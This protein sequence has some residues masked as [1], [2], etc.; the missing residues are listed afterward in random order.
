MVH[1]GR[2]WKPVREPLRLWTGQGQG[3]SPAGAGALAFV[4]RLVVQ[5]ANVDT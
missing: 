5:I 3:T 1:V 2:F 4:A